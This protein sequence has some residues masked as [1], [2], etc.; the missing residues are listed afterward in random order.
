MQTPSP[1]TSV[2]HWQRALFPQLPNSVTQKSVPVQILG[3]GVV[4]VVVVV[5]AV[6]TPATHVDVG[7]LQHA[8][9][10]EQSPPSPT[11]ATQTSPT[12]AHPVKQDPSVQEPPGH[13]FG[14]GVVVVVVVGA[15]VVVVVTGGCGVVDVVVEVVVVVGVGVVEVVVGP[16]HSLA[17]WTTK[18]KGNCF[19]IRLR[20]LRPSCS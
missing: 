12:Q 13:V 11:Q 5:G 19:L 8:T 9:P 20:A 10:V 18:L 2:P 15:T 16:G 4:V 17:S 3:A 6:H 14:A 1:L 7:R